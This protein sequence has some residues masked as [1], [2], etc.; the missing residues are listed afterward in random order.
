MPCYNEAKN[1]A[2]EE[3]HSFIERHSAVLICFVNDGSTDDTLLILNKLKS[4][5]PSRI[6][7]ISYKKNKGK[8]EAVRE[9]FL[10]CHKNYNY[11][12]IAYLD[13][14][15]ATTLE[16]CVELSTQ[17]VGE[18]NFVF[19]SRI[20]KIGSTIK[21][22]TKRFLIGR[23]I[24]TFISKIL[25]LKV[26][27]TQCGCKIFTKDLASQLFREKFISKWLFDVELFKRMLA[28]YGKE[29]ALK[30]MIEIPLKK[31]ID[32]GDSKVKFSYFFKLWIDLIR[33]NNAYKIK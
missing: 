15:L 25:G 33:I 32:K 23:V 30:K 17:L 9:G 20:M 6:N 16:E 31:W 4:S 18:V 19:G 10:F 28:I 21:R 29:A 8:A 1:F 12:N 24:A 7:I 26:Y 14:D 22:T 13:A 5:F 2:L 27:D 3:Y 11:Q